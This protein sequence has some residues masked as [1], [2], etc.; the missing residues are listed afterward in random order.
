MCTYAP[1]EERGPRGIGLSEAPHAARD[2]AM[3]RVIHP[4]APKP[5]RA[6]GDPLA[7]ADLAGFSYG[8]TPTCQP[9]LA[10]AP[11]CSVPRH[12]AKKAAFYQVLGM[13]TSARLQGHH[14]ARDLRLRR[15]ES[16]LEQKL[17][18]QWGTNE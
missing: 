16:A 18:V 11:A 15:R 12:R 9:R 13:G 14:G 17:P 10:P 6:G 7:R 8:P 1:S 2:E 5:H 3:L 4:R